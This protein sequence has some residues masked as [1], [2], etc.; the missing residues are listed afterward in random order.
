MDAPDC[1]NAAMDESL[2]NPYAASR[3]KTLET[4]GSY[5]AG[6][7]FGLFVVVADAALGDDARNAL[8]KTAEALD[9]GPDGVTFL[10]ID[11]SEPVLNAAQVFEAIEGLDPLCLIVCGEQALDVC[12]QAYRHSVPPMQRLRLFGRE[13]C[14]LD[15]LNTLMGDEQGKQRVWHL[16]KSL[17]KRP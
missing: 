5:L 12:A 8:V 3:R 1:Y 4:F 16:L 10:T 7:A 11:A 9:Y 6:S 13:A 2:E 17:P 15:D 14:A